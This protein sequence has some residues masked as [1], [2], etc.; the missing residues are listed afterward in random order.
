MNLPFYIARRYLIAKKSQNVINIISGISVIGVAVGT[1]A[2]VIILSV[3]NGFDDLIKSLYSTFDPE[4]KITLSEGK[5]YSPVLPEFERIRNLNGVQYFSEV[6]EENVLLRYGDRQYIATLKGVDEEFSNVTGI[7]TMIVDGEFELYQQNRPYAV[8]GQGVAYYLGIGLNFLNPLNIYSIRR[9]GNI[10]VNPEQA[11]NRKF[12][13]PSGVFSIEQE[14][15]VKYVITPITFARD[16]LGYTDE[17]SAVEIKLFPDADHDKVQEEIRSILGDEYLVQNRNE[18]N[19]LFYRIM[20]SEKWA[21]FFILT[22]ILIVASFNIIGSLT[23]LILDKKEDINT[24][25]SLGASNSLIRKIFLLEG[26]MIS[27]LGA[28]LGLIIGSFVAWLQAEYGMIKL[29]SSGSFIIDAYPVVYKLSDVFK[30]FLTVLLIG[31]LAAWY[32]V[33]YISKKFLVLS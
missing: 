19:E 16:L 12:I 22:F 14:H 18:Q 13:F 26:W 2:L 24:L 21:I 20:K 8:V 9:T 28:I 25:R 31:L 15:N 32:P 11:I 33:R 7:D 4:I 5:T 23:M 1:M 27:V 3:F 6:L 29:N 30:I 17:V 10:P